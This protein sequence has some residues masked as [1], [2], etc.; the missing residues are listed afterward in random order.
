MRSL[1]LR[2]G[3]RLS[4][5][6]AYKLEMHKMRKLRC[7]A[8]LILSLF[9]I[10]NTA[11]ALSVTRV[12][13]GDTIELSDGQKVR[14]LGVAY[15]RD[16]NRYLAIIIYYKINMLVNILF[17]FL[18]NCRISRQTHRKIYFFQKSI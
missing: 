2:V 8:Y 17:F 9:L 16:G 10:T 12:I 6:K 4:L 7:K 13:D 11:F 18:T 1:D 15:R 3:Y 5:Y 14:L